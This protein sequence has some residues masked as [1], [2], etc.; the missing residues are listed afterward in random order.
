MDIV[1]S[2]IRPVLDKFNQ[3]L[4]S[5]Q[6]S[7]NAKGKGKEQDS[8]DDHLS[9]LQLYLSDWHFMSF[10]DTIGIFDR[11]IFIILLS[12]TVSP[13]CYLSLH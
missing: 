5:V 4:S 1:T 11:V 9:E 7:N 12:R 13:M 2:K 8:S 6:V 10:I 3:A